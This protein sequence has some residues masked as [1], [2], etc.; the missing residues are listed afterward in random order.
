MDETYE[1]N[2]MPVVTTHGPRYMDETLRKPPHT[3][4][5]PAYQQATTD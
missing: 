5:T 1:S 3:P 4:Q 2:G